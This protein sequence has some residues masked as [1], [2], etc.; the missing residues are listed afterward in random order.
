SAFDISQNK[1]QINSTLTTLQDVRTL[2]SNMSAGMPDTSNVLSI[3]T[4]ASVRSIA[5]VTGSMVSVILAAVGGLIFSVLTII[6]IGY[7]DDRLQ[8][9]DSLE[10]IDGVKV[11]GPLGMIPHNKLPLYVN[12]MPGT[13]EAE[14]LRQLRAKIVLA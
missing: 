3:F 12:S 8:W 13:I 7:F 4:A 1:D 11:L 2:Y 14:V 6:L 5:V 10:Q 9:H